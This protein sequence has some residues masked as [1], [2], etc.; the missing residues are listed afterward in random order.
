MIMSCIVIDDEPHA[1]EELRDLIL[2]IPQ[3]N[4]LN[5][6]TD[7]RRAITFV[8]EEGMVDIIFSDISMSTLNGLDAAKILNR[9]CHF[10]IFVTAHREYA[11]EAFGAQ[12]D[13]YLV[14]PLNYLDF[15]DKMQGIT[16]KFQDIVKLQRGE[17]QFLFI[18][19]GQKSS[20]V[21]IKYSDIVCIEALLNYILI[22]TIVS[23][24]ITYISLKSMEDRL[25]TLETFFRISK[26]VII[27]LNHL[28]RIDGNIVRLSTGR[29]YQVG[30]KY[31]AVFLEF[32]KKYSLNS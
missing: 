30:D 23:Q 31:K 19:G 32:L 25:Q 3:L 12:A 28:D 10:L 18:K 15:Y 17:H 13:A 6:F 27:S 24:E 29:T 20:Y 8:Q 4:L 11:L 26:G 2:Q 16:T 14:K 9:Y 22:Y 21:R 7:A 5:T 1:I